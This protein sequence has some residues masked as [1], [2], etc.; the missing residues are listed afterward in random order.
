MPA[1]ELIFSVAGTI[2]AVWSIQS[3]LQPDSQTVNPK[4]AMFPER[5]GRVSEP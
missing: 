3:L 5:R 4:A 2:L 1:F